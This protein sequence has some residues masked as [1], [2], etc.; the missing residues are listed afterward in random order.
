MGSKVRNRNLSLNH[1][2]T[3]PNPT[4]IYQSSSFYILYRMPIKKT[5]NESRTK[6]ALREQSPARV[7]ARVGPRAK[8]RRRPVSYPCAIFTQK[9]WFSPLNSKSDHFQTKPSLY[10]IPTTSITSYN[11]NSYH[12][13]KIDDHLVIN[14][15]K[16]PIWHQQVWI[17]YMHRL[18]KFYSIMN[19]P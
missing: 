6:N 4:K 19:Q 5:P 18:N 7:A 13:H 8:P 12:R 16:W 17:S 1:S 11:I 15:P 9:R 14:Q 3:L 2:K 10:N